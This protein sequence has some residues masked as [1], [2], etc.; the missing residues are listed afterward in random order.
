MADILVDAGPLIALL[1]R[2]DSYHAA[3]V[4]IFR[5]LNCVFLTTLP[6]ITEAMY[7]LQAYGGPAGRD[8]LWKMILRQDLLLEHPTLTDLTRMDELMRKYADL[9]MD[10]ADASLVAVAERLS[11]SRV[12]TLDRSDF[13][14][15]RIYGT[16]AF[17][18]VGP[19]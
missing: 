5:E 11:L 19:H 9:P 13:S 6:V 15:Y 7:F 17:S 10:F 4:P 16:R 2:T 8:G 14:V 3:C 1:S 18:I 12:F